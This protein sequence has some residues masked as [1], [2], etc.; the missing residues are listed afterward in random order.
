[1]FQL[2]TKLHPVCASQDLR[3]QFNFKTDDLFFLEQGWM[4]N[5]DDIYRFPSFTFW[6]IS[7]PTYEQQLLQL[8]K[9]IPIQPNSLPIFLRLV[10]IFSS[11]NCLEFRTK[12][13]ISKDNF[14]ASSLVSKLKFALKSNKHSNDNFNWISFLISNP[15]NELQETRLSRLR[16]LFV[17][18]SANC[19][20][21]SIQLII[22]FFETFLNDIFDKLIQSILD[23]SFKSCLKISF[24]DSPVSSFISNPNQFI[25]DSCFQNLK[26]EE[27]KTSQNFH[28]IIQSISENINSSFEIRV[29]LQASLK[30]DL[31]DAK[32]IV[33]DNSI[34]L[35]TNQ[36]EQEQTT[37]A[38]NVS[39]VL[40][41]LNQA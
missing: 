18:L 9:K 24:N 21:K 36:I 26:I 22:K 12:K 19:S 7:Q 3:L 38:Q 14:I 6:L 23:D 28:N 41:F 27:A 1:M 35:I 25:H 11:F 40:S 37:F 10:R 15:P 34:R 8:F 5:K 20:N 17:F 31:Y 29:Q 32:R 2:I 30:K 33:S 39:N 16:G 4:N 13:T